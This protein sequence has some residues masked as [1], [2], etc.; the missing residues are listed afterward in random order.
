MTVPTSAG[1]VVLHTKIAETE[2]EAQTGGVAIRF[3][4][5]G[6]IK[7]VAHGV[8]SPS[9]VFILLVFALACLAFEQTQP[10]FGFA[11]FAGVF[12]LAL[13]VWGM[14]FV[15]PSWLGLG[16]LL[17]GVGAMVLDVRMRRF[18]VATWFGLGLFLAGSVLLYS[19]VA[20][21]IRIS[22]W[23]LGLTTVAT[24]VFYGFGLT[25][26]T[27]SRDRIVSTQRGLIGLSGEARGRLA[28][29]GPVY[30]KGALWRGR[31]LGLPI[32]AGTR[33]RVRG[34][35]GMVLKVEAEAAGPEDREALP[36]S[37]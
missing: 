21:A 26:A 7:R 24:F 28:P 37:D 34:V 19:G 15:P 5:L 29:D 16:L 10:G 9:M 22:P 11:G 13:A 23:L 8:A 6:P 30:V 31:T 17:A 4:E 33:V 14:T 25:V 20:P 35:D 12:L 2:A 1:P 18:G 36:A 3:H 32:D 27:Q